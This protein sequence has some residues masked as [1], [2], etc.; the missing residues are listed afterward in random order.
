MI[1]KLPPT[2][3]MDSSTTTII[4]KP[5]TQALL[6]P[7]DMKLNSSKTMSLHFLPLPP[8]YQA[9]KRKKGINGSWE[10]SLSCPS[11]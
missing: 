2:K 3:L 8:A 4:A 10:A 1:P 11:L 6:D 9:T 7:I 5:S